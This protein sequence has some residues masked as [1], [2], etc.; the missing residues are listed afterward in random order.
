MKKRLL[1]LLCLLVTAG[2]AA[3]ADIASG[4]C[5][6]GTWVIDDNGKLVITLSDGSVL[7]LGAVKGKDGENGADGKGISTIA[8]DH[9]DGNT[10]TYIITYT[11]NT[12]STFT[13]TKKTHMAYYPYLLIS[14]FLSHSIFCH[15][16]L[17]FLTTCAINHL[18]Y[19]TLVSICIP[20]ITK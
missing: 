19:Q 13:I 7:D 15:W 17:N 18:Q 16:I 20:M 12:T 3:W 6:N 11:D 9:S 2:S 4:T 14:L 10:D 8:F 1:L 5:K